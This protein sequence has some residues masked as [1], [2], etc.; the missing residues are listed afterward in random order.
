MPKKR[1]QTPKQASGTKRQSPYLVFVSHATHDK[2][3]ASVICEKIEVIGAQT[4]RDDRDIKGGESIPNA[5]VDTIEKCDEFLV[6]LTP[7]SI[8]RQWVLVEIGIAIGARVPIVPLLYHLDAEALPGIIR[9]HR[10]YSLN[11][12]EEY[13]DELLERLD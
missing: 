6:L 9:D 2:W 11:E 13:L 10:A 8:N 12:L 7:E 5:I 4:F 3:I 1:R